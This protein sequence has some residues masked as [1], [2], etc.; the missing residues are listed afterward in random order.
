MSELR[1]SD[2]FD[3][4]RFFNPNGSCTR[5]IGDLLTW[6]LTSKHS[7][8]KWP[9]FVPNT[10]E[11]RPLKN[12]LPGE[13]SV[14]FIGQA[15][16]V[17]QMGETNILLDPV[18]SDRVS[19]VSWIGPKRVRPP[20]IKLQHLPATHL[21][22]LSHCHYDHLDL[23]TLRHLH[24]RYH[25]QVVTPLQNRTLIA[26]TGLTEITELDWW[27]S[28][29]VRGL[30]ITLT[31][32]QHF[33]ARKLSD[34]NTRLW[35]GFVIE[36]EGKTIYF[37]ADTGYAEHFKEVARRFPRIDLALLP[38]G[39]YEPR[40]FMK[41]YHMNPADAVQAFLDLKPTRAIGMHFGTFQLTDEGIDEPQQHLA[42]ELKD[43]GLTREQFRTLDFGETASF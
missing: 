17:L 28:T 30:R 8:K 6:R 5:G 20:G 22:L 29:E 31:P 10:I 2:H 42:A 23:R 36:G 14:T 24:F 38:I 25:P 19:P 21:L 3:G 1:P 32:A 12:C 39:A 7:R 15:S 40:W 33:S 11:S 27:Q 16:F 4:K 43:K 9:D 18:L 34:R 41:D 13:I 26:T 35:G 37:A